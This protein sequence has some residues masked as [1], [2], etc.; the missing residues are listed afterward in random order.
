MNDAQLAQQIEGVL[1]ATGRPFSYEE[2][3][4]I[5]QID[6][7]GVTA[8][9]AHLQNQKEKGMV[10][11]DDGHMVEL[12]VAPEVAALVE[13]IKRD[14]YSRD[15]GKAGLEVVAAI[16]YRGPLTRAEID[17]IRGV[18]SSQIIRTLTMRGLMRRI[19]NP[20]D[21]RSFLYE[22]TTELLASIG[23]THPRDLP[24]FDQVREK[25]AQLEQAYREH[26]NRDS[27]A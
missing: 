5:L 27:I 10:L 22:A 1:F 26:T 19:S 3:Q 20:K 21:E 11:L 6:A 25:L 7:E 2:L 16:L 8:A 4:T 15:I 23:A 14:E 24:D 13:K 17:F 9:L 12:R 18:N